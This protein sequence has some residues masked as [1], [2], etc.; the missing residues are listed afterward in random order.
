ME[1]HGSGDRKPK[2]LK[3]KGCHEW[4][5]VAAIPDCGSGGRWFKPTQLYQFFQR[6][7]AGSC[8]H[9]VR[10]VGLARGTFAA[11]E[12]IPLA[13]NWSGRG[14]Q[15]SDQQPLLSVMVMRRGEFQH[16]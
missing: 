15:Q 5:Q 11:H 3:V 4:K 7:S 13:A 12:P 16:N 1:A 8:Q 6:F 14:C 2:N 9:S 10:R